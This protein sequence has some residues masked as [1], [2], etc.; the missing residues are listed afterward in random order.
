MQTCATP[1]LW[2]QA[3]PE[4]TGSQLSIACTVTDK[5]GRVQL[6][7]QTITGDE[8]L[9]SGG[10]PFAIG[11]GDITALTLLQDHAQDELVG[12]GVTVD[13][14]DGGVAN[15]TFQQ[16]L[17]A[18]LVPFGG[19]SVNGFQMSSGPAITPVAVIWTQNN[20]PIAGQ[21]SQ[22]SQSFWEIIEVVSITT[23]IVTS[24]AVAVRTPYLDYQEDQGSDIKLQTGV[25]MA[26]GQTVDFYW[27]KG[28]TP[29]A[30]SNGIV[31][32]DLPTISCSNGLILTISATNIQAGDQIYPI[33]LVF[34]VG[35]LTGLP[36]AA[37]PN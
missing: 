25:N 31:V 4:A 23:R 21:P 19:V 20:Q 35:R 13:L 27:V 32:L 5:S 29:A 26:A 1:W 37:I 18:G 36:P 7:N 14:R 17:F 12:Y 24:A 15:A 3:T 2:I 6:Y 30:L 28:A 10:F 34:K 11:A 22:Y 8:A 16:R 33:T 9:T